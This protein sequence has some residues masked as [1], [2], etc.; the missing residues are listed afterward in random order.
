MEVLKMKKK[1]ITTPAILFF[2]FFTCT[3]QTSDSLSSKA[4]IFEEYITKMVELGEFNGNILVAEKGEVIYRRSI[5]QRSAEVGDL[6]DLGAQFNLASASLQ[7]MAMAIMQMKEAGKLEYEDPIQKYIPEFPYEGI[8]IRTLLNQ[9][10][11]LPDVG[12]MFNI[13]W[14]PWLS[15][16][17]PKRIIEG[18]EQMIQMFINHQVKVEYQPGEVYNHNLADYMLLSVIAERVIGIPL[19]QYMREN[20]FLPAGMENTYKF[21][22]L[23]EDP[24]TNRAYG[25]MPALDGSGLTTIDFNYL[26]PKGGGN[27]YSTLE[28]LYRWD[29]ILY[30]E[31]LVSASTLEEAFTPV[32]LNSSDTTNAGWG[33]DIRKTS[34]GGKILYQDGYYEGFGISII[35]DLEKENSIIILTNYNLYLWDGLIQ[36]LRRIMEGKEYKLPKKK[37]IAKVFGP[38]LMTKGIEIA[39]QQY[40]DLQQNRAGDY[41]FEVGEL[42]DLGCTM[43]RYGYPEEA[44]LVFQFNS[45]EYPESATFV[46]H[47]LALCYLFLGDTQNASANFRKALEIDPDFSPS[48]EVLEW[49]KKYEF[50]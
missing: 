50:Y 37:S 10:S 18:S 45:E 8:T 34:S 46:W 23:R 5:G 7:F 17:Y 48:N 22:P 19:H 6:L 12:Y 3:S 16:Y 28:D 44:L 1:F 13:H 2:L 40:F 14:K 11:G 29:R 25:I 20:L 41:N 38:T 31:K 9:T 4:K 15:P 21:S 36:N 43:L 49:M 39:R 47:S 42:N 30:T 27:V 33:C 35:R 26:S 24:L 32:I